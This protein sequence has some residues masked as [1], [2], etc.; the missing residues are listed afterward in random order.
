MTTALTKSSLVP[1]RESG[2]IKTS[3]AVTKLKMITLETMVLFFR[4]LDTQVSPPSKAERISSK[5]RRIS[6][7]VKVKRIKNIVREKLNG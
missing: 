4:F 7:S 6:I 1:K 5:V 3:R 2:T